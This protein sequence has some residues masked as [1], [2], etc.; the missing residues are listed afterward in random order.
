M[1]DSIAVIS[2]S[3]TQLQETTF[4]N[5]L[6]KFE[7]PNGMLIN[8]PKL[9][10]YNPYVSGQRLFIIRTPNFIRDMDGL[11][12]NN[13]SIEDILA[14]H[15]DS[16]YRLTPVNLHDVP[17]IFYDKDTNTWSSKS[18]GFHTLSRSFGWER[19]KAKPST[20]KEIWGNNQIWR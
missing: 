13:H 12:I 1:R 15:F 10:E 6:S 3:M 16:R 19:G 8:G 2:P 18:N 5:L 9:P 14:D 11:F 17:H 4:S 7:S 20:E